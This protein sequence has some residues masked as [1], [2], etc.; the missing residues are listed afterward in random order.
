MNHFKMRQPLYNYSTLTTTNLSS[1]QKQIQVVRVLIVFLTLREF[2][3]LLL[4]FFAV[5]V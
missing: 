1:E 2:Q 5:V 4:H 3:F